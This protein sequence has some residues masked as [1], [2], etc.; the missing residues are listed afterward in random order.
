MVKYPQGFTLDES[1][2]QSFV[3]DLENAN[4]AFELNPQELGNEQNGLSSTVIRLYHEWREKHGFK[5]SERTDSELD[6]EDFLDGTL[7]ILRPTKK[8]GSQIYL[9]HDVNLT[10]LMLTFEYLETVSSRF[11]QD[12]DATN[13][14]GR[15]VVAVGKQVLFIY[16][17]SS[18]K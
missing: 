8:N 14:V 15:M 7:V 5:V 13:E 11:L 9:K 2:K 18:L 16:R 12:P 1:K 10:A 4:L 6:S 3:R 17:N